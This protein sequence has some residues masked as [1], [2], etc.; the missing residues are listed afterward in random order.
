MEFVATAVNLLSQ[1]YLRLMT[2]N[3]ATIPTN[4]NAIISLSSAILTVISFCV[5]IAPIPLTGLVCFPVSA[6]LGIAALATG[7]VS[8]R[9]IRASE[10]KGRTLALFGAWVGGLTMLV[11]LCT[12][13]TWILLLPEIAHLIVQIIK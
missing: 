3:T 12:I 8:L 6:I 5:G 7:L 11:G 10:E 4:T 9:Q 2:E 1:I 13:V